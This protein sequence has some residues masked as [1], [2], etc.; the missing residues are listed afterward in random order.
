MR[1]EGRTGADEIGLLNRAFNRMTSQLEK[2]TDDLIAKLGTTHFIA[3]VGTS[4][5]GK[6]SLVRTGMIAGLETGFLAAAGTRWKIAE[7]RPNQKRC[8]GAKAGG[9]CGEGIL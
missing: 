6:S 5:C 7:M 9:E 2:Q 3:V 1:V 4:G 8:V